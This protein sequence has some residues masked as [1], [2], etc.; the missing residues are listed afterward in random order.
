[1]LGVGSE[2]A[3]SLIKLDGAGKKSLTRRNH[4]SAFRLDSHPDWLCSLGK[5]I[6]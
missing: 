3:E 4:I 2:I 5:S 1:M 6:S